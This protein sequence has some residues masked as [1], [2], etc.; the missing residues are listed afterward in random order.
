MA[1]PARVAAGSRGLSILLIASCCVVSLLS[2]IPNAFNNISSAVKADFGES[3]L[4]MAL[5]TGVGVANLQF[6]LLGGVFLDKYG[7][8]AATAV[9]G[10]VVVVSLV[11]MSFVRS[12]VALFVLY[13]F[14]SLGCGTTFISSLM[15]AID[16]G[17]SLGIGAVSLCMSLSL[18]ATV[19]MTDLYAH[20]ACESTE[21]PSCWREYARLYAAVCGGAFALGLAGMWWVARQGRPRLKRGASGGGAAGPRSVADGG[22]EYH[23]FDSSASASSSAASGSPKA[24]AP[25]AAEAAMESHRTPLGGGGHAVHPAADA[26]PP[27][28]SRGSAGVESKLLGGDHGPARSRSDLSSHVSRSAASF[29]VEEQGEDED[30]AEADGKCEGG[31][32][33]LGRRRAA[34]VPYSVAYE[35]EAAHRATAI[36]REAATH[37]P[38]LSCFFFCLVL[39]DMAGIGCGLFVITNATD[40][41]A[42]FAGSPSYQWSNAIVIAFS[43]LNG[44][45]NV[46]SPM[47]SDALFHRHVT[48]RTRFLSYLLVAAAAIYLGLGLLAG[49]YDDAKATPSTAAKVAFV[50][51][52]SSVGIVFGSFLTLMPTSV[53][54]A[55]GIERF[56]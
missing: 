23:T 33:R 47:V 49:H 18:S 50:A 3:S 26:L 7:A 9:A 15:T 8:R 39:G 51:L 21:H 30:D 35:P 19:L 42:S 41:W 2:G 14:F 10:S 36:L 38:P 25:A 5:L 43:V 56:G 6:T 55:Y 28:P 53:A 45:G 29:A 24:P 54:D 4:F 32:R 46:F 31:Q 52:A 34:T 16:L 22:C 20:A 17:L 13:F 40:L 1:A 12:P 48:S 11:A 44:L 37:A 27:S